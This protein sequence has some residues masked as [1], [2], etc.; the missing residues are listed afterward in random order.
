M[1]M[2]RALEDCIANISTSNTKHSGAVNGDSENVIHGNR[3]NGTADSALSAIDAD[4]EVEA[5]VKFL[6]DFVSSSLP[7]SR[8]QVL[9]SAGSTLVLS[10]HHPNPSMRA[11]AISQLG[12]TLGS[13]AKVC[14]CVSMPM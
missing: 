10:V 11:A 4:S 12:K 3:G 6:H 1:L 5:R 13:K 2:D 8:H 7:K 14:A 9:T